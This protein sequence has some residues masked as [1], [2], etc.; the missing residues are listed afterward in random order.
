[1]TQLLISQEKYRNQ[2]VMPLGSYH[3]TFNWPAFTYICPEFLSCPPKRERAARDSIS[4]SAC[5]WSPFSHPLGTLLSGVFPP[6]LV[7]PTHHAA[8]FP[9]PLQ[10]PHCSPFF[11]PCTPLNSHPN[12]CPSSPSSHQSHCPLLP[13]HTLLSTPPVA[14]G[15]FPGICTAGPSFHL[16]LSLALCCPGLPLPSAILPRILCWLLELLPLPFPQT[17]VL[18]RGLSSS[19]SHLMLHSPAKSSIPWL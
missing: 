18:A 1:M 12:S 3:L 2:K 13:G 4:P 8:S 14:S 11:T 9:A 6:S 7:R 19:S 15:T 5:E 17:L 16:H 10:R